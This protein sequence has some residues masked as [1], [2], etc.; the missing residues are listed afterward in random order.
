MADRLLAAIGVET[1]ASAV[2]R[3]YG[4][5]LLD[6]WLVDETDSGLVAE[7]TALGIACRAVPLMMTDQQAAAD[8][9]RAALDLADAGRRA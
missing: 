6:G 8:M 2:A 1:T 7:V 3:H 9:A 5:E 4:P